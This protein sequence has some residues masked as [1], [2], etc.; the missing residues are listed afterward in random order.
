MADSVARYSRFYQVQW[1]DTDLTGFVHFSRYL[2]MME[3]TEYAFLRSRGLSVV[4]RDERGMMG[5]PRLAANIDV[6][7]PLQID[8]RVEI[9]LILERIDGKQI[10]YRFEIREGDGVAVRGYFRVATCRFPADGALYAILIPS[11][12]QDRLLSAERP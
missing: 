5:F 11:W 9:R 8:Q 12:I 3:E 10:E 1:V 2:Q 6:V 7:R 4:M